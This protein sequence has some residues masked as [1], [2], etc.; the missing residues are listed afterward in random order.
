M[1]RNVTGLSVGR[2]VDECGQADFAPT[3]FEQEMDREAYEVEYLDV[4]EMFCM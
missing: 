3:S 4:E 1:R 2:K